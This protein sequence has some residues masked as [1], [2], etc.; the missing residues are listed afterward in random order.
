MFTA[1]IFDHLREKYGLD[2][3]YEILESSEEKRYGGR[4]FTY[5]FPPTD[6]SKKDESYERHAYY[7]VGAMRFPDIGIMNR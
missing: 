7:D 6:T 2:V 4:L 3:E 1:M 5:R